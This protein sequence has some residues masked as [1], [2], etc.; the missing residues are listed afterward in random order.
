MI[1]PFYQHTP[2]ENNS[3]SFLFANILSVDAGNKACYRRSIMAD[4]PYQCPDCRLDLV[5][6]T[7][8]HQK[9]LT[10]PS[11]KKHWEE[12]DGVYLFGPDLYWGEIPEAEMRTYLQD[13]QAQGLKA[14]TKAFIKKDPEAKDAEDSFRFF[15]D[16]SRADWRFGTEMKATDRVLDVGCGMGGNTFALCDLVKEVVAFDLSWMRAKFVQLRAKEEGKN[17]IQIFCGDFMELPLPEGQFDVIIFNGIL[18]W[19]G[20]SVKFADPYDVQVWVMQKCHRLLKPGGRFYI[21]IENRW[22]FSYLT[23]SLDHIGLRWT[24]WMPRWIA[25]PYTKWRLGKDYRTYTHG[26]PGYVKLL[27]KGGFKDIHVMMPYPGYNEQRIL[28]PFGNTACLRYAITSL[29]G[30]LSWKK[31]LMKSLASIPGVLALYRYFFFSY[32][33]YAVKHDSPYDSA[34]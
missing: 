15:F 13:I 11:C 19:I 12:K 3:F 14:A 8:D 34:T 20:Q 25:R 18:E 30:N 1:A 29:M 5:E 28:I 32:N 2:P 6:R 4:L 27:Q 21:G 9:A 10:C 7:E 26:Q 33:L 31:K 24:S 17:N 16:H 23:G 22:A